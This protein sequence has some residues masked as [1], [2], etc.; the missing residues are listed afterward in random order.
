MERA[1]NWDELS[2]FEL[3]AYWRMMRHHWPPAPRGHCLSRRH[4]PSWKPELWRELAQT[5][6]LLD[7]EAR[8]V[9]EFF[10]NRSFA[11]VDETSKIANWL[12]A[13]DSTC[14]SPR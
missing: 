7:Q 8:L 13:P 11:V 12:G 1:L 5:L 9:R 3:S 6:R 4:L 14:V 2:G 10:S